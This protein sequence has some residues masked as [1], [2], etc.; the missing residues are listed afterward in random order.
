ME[1]KYQKETDTLTFYLEGELDHHAA[2]KLRLE[3]DEKIVAVRAARVVLDL[4]GTEF[5]DSSGLGLILGRVRVAQNAGA[6][7]S[8]AGANRRIRRILE[9]CGAQQ[10]L[11]FA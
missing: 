3:L 6:T 7:L 9:L 5:L 11:S 8:V 2:Q 10:Y 1:S 4:S